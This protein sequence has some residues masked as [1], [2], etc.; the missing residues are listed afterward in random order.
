MATKTKATSVPIYPNGECFCGC[1]EV[2]PV[3]SYFSPGHDKRAE[4]MIVKMEYGSIVGLLVAKGFGP[5]G[6]NV[7]ETYQEW[8][9]SQDADEG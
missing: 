5:G 8:Q 1:G 4:S 7:T 9:Q 3:G 2:L 6:K